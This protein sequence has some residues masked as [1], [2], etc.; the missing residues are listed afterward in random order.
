MIIFA[1][2][3]RIMLE[4]ILP[5]E[6]ELFYLI[7]GHHHP[8]LDPIMWLLSNTILLIPLIVFLVI[9]NKNKK[10]NQIILPL[11]FALAFVFLLGDFFS[12][13]IIKPNI[14]RLRPT[15]YPGIQEYVLTVYDYVG[16]KFGF[17]S[18]H[19]TNSIGFATFSSL[20][21]RKKGYSWGIYIWALAV[22]Y[23]RVYLGVHFIS[24]LVAGS[25]LGLAIGWL[26]YKLY[27]AYVC[28]VHPKNSSV[29]EKL[30]NGTVIFIF[31]LLVITTLKTEGLI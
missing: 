4:R 12:S 3:F 16:K 10:D 17:L 26:V 21:L 14:Q 13:T 19:A 29:Q 7:N 25:C 24:D 27:Q 30:I 31:I 23:S 8:W 15:H 2:K 28:K 5:Y 22:C 9:I 20:L 6:T 1:N 11:F 18:G